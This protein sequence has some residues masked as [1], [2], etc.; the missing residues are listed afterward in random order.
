MKV[1]CIV[2]DEPSIRKSIANLLRSEGYQPICFDSGATFL[3]SPWKNKADCLLL[4]M[5]MYGL[6]GLDVQR[7]LQEEGNT[8]PVICMSAFASERSIEQSLQAGASH[9]LTKPFTAEALLDMIAK[10][11]EGR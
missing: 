3:S 4:D 10:T 8:L 6:Q 7:V 11:V 1:V 5:R 9:F 2:D